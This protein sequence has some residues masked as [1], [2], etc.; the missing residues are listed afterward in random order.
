VPTSTKAEAHRPTATQALLEV[1]ET[2]AKELRES[3]GEAGYGVRCN[4]QRRPPHRIAIVEAGGSDAG[5]PKPAPTAVQALADVHDTP[6]APPPT[7]G[8]IE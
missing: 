8:V 2:P 4:L 3:W 1:Q 6:A 5:P 7:N